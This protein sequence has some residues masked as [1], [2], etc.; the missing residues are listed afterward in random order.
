MR[1]I[2]TLGPCVLVMNGSGSGREDQGV[3]DFALGSVA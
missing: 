3:K 2:G 1:S